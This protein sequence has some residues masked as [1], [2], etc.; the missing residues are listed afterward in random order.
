MLKAASVNGTVVV[1]DGGAKGSVV[2]SYAPF[3]AQGSEGDRAAYELLAPFDL[4]EPSVDG[5]AA[6]YVDV[7]PGV[8]LV[9]EA[10]SAGFSYFFVVNTR[11]AAKSPKLAELRIPLRLNGLKPKASAGGTAFVDADGRRLVWSGTPMMWDAK[12]G[13]VAPDSGEEATDG[14]APSDQVA[15][16]DAEA[17]ATE[18]VLKP[19]VSLLA[20]KETALPVVIDPASSQPTRNGWTAVWSNYPTTSFWQTEHSLGAGYEGWE[21]NKK[22]RSYFRFPIT[23][24]LKGTRVL[25]AAMNVKQIHA[26]QCAEHPTDVYRTDP[27]GTA[28][29]WNRQPARGALQDT[30]YSYAGCGSG[31]NWV[32]WNVKYGMQNIADQGVSSG[33]FMIRGRDESNKYAWKQFD[34]DGAHLE[35][36][37]MPYPNT[38]TT[39]LKDS[40]GSVACGSSTD[41][42]IVT[43]T[44][45]QLGAKVSIRSATDKLYGSFRIENTGTGGTATQVA[46]TGKESGEISWVARTV[47]NGHKYRIYSRARVYLNSAKSSYLES[48]ATAGWCYFRVDTSA[49]KAPTLTSSNFPEC[50]AEASPSTCP[51]TGTRVGGTG[52]F[53]VDAP[54]SDVVKYQWW[55]V[56]PASGEPTS[57]TTVTTTG[58]AAKT[59][60]FTPRKT[61][62]RKIQAQAF[63]EAGFG[64]AVKTYEFYVAANAPV[65]DWT[66]DNEAARGANTGRD[67]STG[68]LSLGGATISNFGRADDGLR[69]TGGAPATTTVAGVSTTQDFSVAA[70]VRVS[71]SESATLVA[72]KSATGDAF[73]LG[74][75]SSSRKWVVG[76]R[77]STETRYASSSA[78]ADVGQWAHLA[79]TYQA[80][81]KT[82]TLYVNGVQNGTVVYT[83]AAESVTGWQLGCGSSALPAPG[84]ANGMVDQ[85]GIWDVAISAPDVDARLKLDSDTR[86]ET[87]T[88]A[89]WDMAADTSASGVIT[90]RSFGAKLAVS[91]AG[92]DYLAGALDGAVTVPAL[93]LPG[94]PSQQAKMAWSPV[95]SSTSFTVGAL[96]RI[97]DGSHAA[98]IAQQ[99]SANT[100]AWTL[101]YRPTDDGVMQFYFR[102]AASDSASAGVSEVRLNVDSINEFNAVTGV[103]DATNN[104]I[105]LYLNGQ[106]FADDDGSEFSPRA[107]DAFTTPWQA[108]GAFS[109][110]NGTIGQSPGG[111]QA[112]FEGDIARIKLFAGALT[113]DAIEKGEDGVTPPFE[114]PVIPPLDTAKVLDVDFADGVI[115]ERVAGL[116]ARV[117][118]APSF[119]TDGTVSSA[120]PTGVM[121]VDGVS[122]AISFAVDPWAQMSGG[123]TM[124]C[125]F[126]IETTLPVSS[127][128]DLC[129]NKEAGG[130]GIYV[131][132]SELRTNA[133]IGGAYQVVSTPAESDRWYH[134]L[135]V[136]DGTTL[137]FYVNG[138]RVGETAAAGALSAPATTARSF[139]IGG[140]SA[141]NN[142]VQFPSPP[143][144]FAH[145]AVYSRS[146]SAS[147]A[148]TMA[149]SWKT[150]PPA[151]SVVA[152]LE[153]TKKLD[154]DFAGSVPNER[155]Q[156]LESRTWGAPAYWTDE[157]ISAE[158]ATQVMRVDGVDD[159]VSFETDP[160]AELSGGFTFECVFRIETTLPVSS[161]RDLCSS[162]EAGGFAIYVEGSEIRAAAHIGGTYQRVSTPTDAPAVSSRWYHAASVWDGTT[163][164]LYVNGARV[165]ETAAAGP[166]TPPAEVARRIVI[167][168]DSGLNQS[169]SFPAP[170][171]SFAHAGLYAR[172]ASATEVAEI[173]GKWETPDTPVVPPLETTMKLDVD[174]AGGAPNEHAQ[175]LSAQVWGAPTYWTDDQ[176]AVGGPTQVMRV[177]G[178]D[179][180]V[181]FADDPWPALA[182]GFTFECVF[183]IESALPVSS[184]RDLCSSKENGGFAISVEGAEIRAAAHVGGTYRKVATPADAPTVSNRWYHVA[185]V[186]DGTTLALYVNGT[187]VGET[188]ATG[189]LTPPAEVAR[190]IMIGGDPG[191]SGGVSFPAPPASFAHAGVYARAAS[192][193]EVAEIAGMWGTPDTPVVPPLE[194]TAKLDVDFAGDTPNEHAQG[195]SA[196]VWGAPTYWTDDQVSDGGP[197]RVMRVDGV[198]DAVSFA[199]DPWPALAGGFTFEC[200]FRIE[201]ALPV[202]SQRDLCSSKEDGGFAIYVEGSEIRA[203]AHI[204]GTYQRV[205]TPTDDPAVSNRWY[206]VASVWDGA[207]LALYVNG[208]RVGDTAAAGPL[209]PPAE[210]ARKI[211]IGGDPGATGGVSFPAPPASFAHAGL[212]ARAAS[213]TEVAEI[214]A[215][216]N[217]AAAPN[218]E[219]TG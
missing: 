121:Q 57:K 184:Q 7:I 48:K 197:M 62:L 106:A 159:A 59:F 66:F 24:A 139:V 132:G 120:G 16:F 131:Q 40:S 71:T 127:E 73:E 87:S 36:S 19:D 142:A 50:A 33:T 163:L 145:T 93:T 91:G 198:D 196:Q 10:K 90:D 117:S 158:G 99:A 137:A 152:P 187:R 122:D 85:V 171:S 125:V 203:A 56:G 69:F 23:S 155:A 58:G 146:V 205:A 206:H 156:S 30:R 112:P 176:V 11:A 82:V 181:S 103:Y 17:S 123:F 195:L 169:V 27:I 136:W 12:G 78:V 129:S 151:D 53:T 15:V 51:H 28:T 174:F 160:W 34:D 79:A 201:S 210:V 140:D 88:A 108:R 138:V 43:S 170:P 177:D 183:R 192:A 211:M 128:R 64:G 154:V 157:T 143:A 38:S 39:Y 84:C 72:G 21:Q 175:G 114:A 153:A 25:S 61:G 113:A 35:I 4:P 1:S 194:A 80:S 204:G 76:R 3:R 218:Q 41:P 115:N 100:A 14:P 118:G 92:S 13:E 22:V 65:A 164:A 208:T 162:K 213:A 18:M 109:L 8:D 172:A 52:T 77:G 188:A 161:H 168:G 97:P 29:T 49:P 212:Y 55:V 96:V 107:E 126:K 47:S 63:D 94:E 180:A 149:A 111:A 105:K 130:F 182:G 219:G 202:S 200:V 165:A 116:A 124:E 141:P 9:V 83:T 193:A 98:V 217:T 70:W 215:T 110:G 74:F 185:S 20:S 89:D 44:D 166:L 190:K 67:P 6:T 46:S 86:E 68:T 179:D 189:T 207:T 31:S 75:D 119:G 102:M 60:S 134:A 37:Y 95:A 214:A 191:A 144:S 26:A 173:A 216:W 147:E 45:I 101:G 135:S 2:A 42:A 81:T 104:V 178:V 199:D 167:G 133:F 32:G 5:S 54:D 209:R 186:W 150:P 148:T